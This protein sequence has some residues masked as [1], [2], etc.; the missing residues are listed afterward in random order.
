MMQW[1]GSRNKLVA[2][3]Y[4]SLAAEV[5]SFPYPEVH[6]NPTYKAPGMTEEETSP[7]RLQVLALR[8]R[9][10]CISSLSWNETETV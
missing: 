1:I 10:F 3:I 9:S 6:L 2:N 8:E 7:W 4:P 5:N